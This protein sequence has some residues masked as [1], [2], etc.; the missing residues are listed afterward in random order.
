MKGFLSTLIWFDCFVVKQ[1]RIV[2]L[3][4]EGHV[5]L[6]LFQNKTSWHCCGIVGNEGGSWVHRVVHPSLTKQKRRPI[7]PYAENGLNMVWSITQT[8]S[9]VHFLFA[10][11]WQ[12]AWLVERKV[13]PVIPLVILTHAWPI[14]HRLR[15]EIIVWE[16]SWNCPKL[17][18]FVKLPISAI[19]R[20]CS[21]WKY[22]SNSKFL[23]MH[24]R[25]SLKVGG[26]GI[27]KNFFFYSTTPYSRPDQPQ[28]RTRNRL[29]VLFL[30]VYFN[31]LTFLDSVLLE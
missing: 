22:A 8:L 31:G 1:K 27:E 30:F 9:R 28:L 10:T 16:T 29:L 18:F 13:I 11:P 20:P 6:K 4:D 5:C 2:C 14:L 21:W 23:W 19:A 25:L 3:T 12:Q 15:T 26:S 24:C 7:N 17:S